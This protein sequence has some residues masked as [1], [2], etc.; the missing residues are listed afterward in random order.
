[1]SYFKKFTDFCSGFAAFTAV[2]YLFRGYMKFD[3]DAELGLTDKLKLFFSR[4]TS[5]QNRMLAFLAIL[6][7][8]SAVCGRIFKRLPYISEAFCIFP[9]LLTMDMLKAGLIAEYPMLY[10]IFGIIGVVG[11]AADCL[12]RDRQDGKHRSA[13]ACA[14]S[15]AV[16]S[17]FCCYV[18]YKSN[19]LAELGLDMSQAFELNRFDYEIYGKMPDMNIKI[20]YAAAIAYAMLAVLC[21]VLSDIYFISAVLSVPPAAALIYLWGADKLTVHSEIAVTLGVIYFVVCIIP[22]IFG[23]ARCKTQK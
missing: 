12:L 16:T 5:E 10:V 1:M 11:A 6:F 22:A 2:M 7:L 9:L 3:F 21:L 15:G 4:A 14:V 18:I 8:L 19:E 20:F 13:Y 23:R 17:A